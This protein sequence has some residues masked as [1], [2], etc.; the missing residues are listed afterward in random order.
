M[1]TSRRIRL[2]IPHSSLPHPI[3]WRGITHSPGSL[4]RSHLI[5]RDYVGISLFPGCYA[6]MRT[7][8]IDR[9]AGYVGLKLGEAKVVLWR[10]TAKTQ[11]ATFLRGLWHIGS[12]PW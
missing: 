1:A 11:S 4:Y 3:H 8:I 9:N 7:T 6:E 2:P 12:V 5:S 10:E